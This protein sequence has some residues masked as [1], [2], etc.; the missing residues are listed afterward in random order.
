M[1][2]RKMNSQTRERKNIFLQKDYMKN[3]F[4]RHEIFSETKT[5]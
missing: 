2:V 4:L 1:Q 3:I 5:P